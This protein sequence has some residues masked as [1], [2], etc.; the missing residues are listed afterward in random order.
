[1]DRYFHFKVNG[2]PQYNIQKK[3]RYCRPCLIIYRVMNYQGGVLVSR[4]AANIRRHPY[5]SVHPATLAFPTLDIIIN[6]FVY[7]SKNKFSGRVSD[8]N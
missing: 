4:A 3:I 6:K 8:S 2:E 7:F 5:P 1:M